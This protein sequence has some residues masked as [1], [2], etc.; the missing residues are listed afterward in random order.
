MSIFLSR[1]GSIKSIFTS[2]AVKWTPLHRINCKLW[3][4]AFSRLHL[5]IHRV[6]GDW[7]FSPPFQE[8]PSYNHCPSFSF[9]SQIVPRVNCLDPKFLFPF[10]AWLPGCKISW[11][12]RCCRLWNSS[13]S[14]Q[15]ALDW[16][17]TPFFKVLFSHF[18]MDFWIYFVSRLAKNNKKAVKTQ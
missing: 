14:F 18:L 12:K 7:R 10:S 17:H 15:P 5:W 3:S 9:R 4:F 16:Q 6:Q 13:E 1:S 8:H 2:G 11:K